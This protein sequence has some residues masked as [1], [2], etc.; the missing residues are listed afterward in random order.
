M[1]GQHIRGSP[2]SVAAKSPVEKLS[3]PILT[4]S[5]VMNPWDVAIT[6]RGEVVVSEYGA[7]RVSVFSVTGEKLRS[8]GTH[9]SGEGQL[10]DPRGVAVDAEGNILVADSS[11]HRIQ[12]FT[13]EGQFLTAVGRPLQQPRC[14][15]FNTRNSKVYVTD[16]NDL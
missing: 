5:G 16:S 15:A 1:E 13:A 8:F 7:D 9:G 3:T 11:N 2:F 14:I 6:H 12:K 10:K 4:L